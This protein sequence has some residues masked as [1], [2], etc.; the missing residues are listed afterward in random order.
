MGSV[1]GTTE[2]RP[3]LDWNPHTMPEVQQRH[4]EAEVE[5]GSEGEKE[6][7]GSDGVL[8]LSVVL[9]GSDTEVSRSLAAA[10]QTRETVKLC[11]MT[12]TTG[13]GTAF[14]SFKV[15]GGAK[16]SACGSLIN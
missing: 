4:M 14:D 10:A 5:R 1:T 7:P 15:P 2:L 12:L 3:G 13:P 8:Q 6:K 11:C 9:G 16:C